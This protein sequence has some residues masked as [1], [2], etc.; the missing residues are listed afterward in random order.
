MYT[1]MTLSA[2]LSA[3]SSTLAKLQLKFFGVF[4]ALSLSTPT[5]V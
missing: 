4:F 2:C 5:N 3:L 1:Y